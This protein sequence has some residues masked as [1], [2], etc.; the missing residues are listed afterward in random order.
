MTKNQKELGKN[1]VRL[2]EQ[3]AASGF[4]GGY[5][6]ILFNDYKEDDCCGK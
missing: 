5:I 2:I 6:A 4:L 1:S 3:E